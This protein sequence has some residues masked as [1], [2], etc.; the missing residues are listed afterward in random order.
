MA[1]ASG[2]KWYRYFVAT[3]EKSDTATP[4]TEPRR[5]NDVVPKPMTVPVPT[6]TNLGTISEVYAS[7]R[8]EP[9]AH[10]YTIQKVADMLAS[11]HIR[12]LPS[13]VKRKSVLV[14]LDAAG[15]SIDDIVQDAVRR[16]QALDTY[17]RVLVQHVNERRDAWL[18]E[19]AAIEEEIT[20]RVAELRARIDE[21]TR[22][23]TREQDELNAWRARKQQEEAAIAEAVGHFVSENPITV[24]TPAPSQGETDVRPA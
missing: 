9:P 2:K 20:K 1:A 12:A 24:A 3:D 10:G 19:N 16:D 15:V 23:I 17:E 4:D 6:E 14:A 22:L 5:A 11:E 21:N 18:A 7:A 13:D 8:I